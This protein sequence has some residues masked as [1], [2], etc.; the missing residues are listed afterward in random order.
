MIWIGTKSTARDALRSFR[1]A[2]C[3]KAEGF[4]SFAFATTQGAHSVLDGAA[5]QGWHIERLFSILFCICFVVYV[6]TILFFAIGGRRSYTS[7]EDPLPVIKTP[8]ADAVAKWWVASAVAVTTVI[9]FVVL[10]LSIRTG[11]Y[12]EN[13]SAQNSV[14]VKVTGHQ[15]WWE[16]TYPNSQPDQ[17][18]FTANEIHVPTGQRIAV[19]TNSADVIHSFWAPSITGKRDLIPGYSTAFS[20]TVDRA[21]TYRGQCAEFCGL[22]HAHMGF[23]IVAESPEEFEAWRQSQLTSA[24]EPES[25]LARRGQSVFLTHACIMCHAISGTTA[26]SHVG[27]DL[28][29]FASRGEIAAGLLPNNPGSLAG[30]IL[31]PQRMKPGTTMPPNNLSGEDLEALVTYLESLR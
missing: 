22:Q 23:A 12:V 27:P 21:G 17:T 6:L 2:R 26:G 24:K 28:T 9:M 8:E 30:W 20:F 5:S 1:T 14:T 15:W 3:S 10:V 11:T 4:W 18:I 29:H 7:H 13:V 31:D 16:V 25:A 19:L